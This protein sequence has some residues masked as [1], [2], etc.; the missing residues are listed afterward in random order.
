MAEVGKFKPKEAGEFR[1]EEIV[2]GNHLAYIDNATGNWQVGELVS[3]NTPPKNADG[4]YVAK[5]KGLNVGAPTRDIIISLPPKK[6]ELPNLVAAHEINGKNYLIDLTSIFVNDDG[7]IE[8]VLV[9]SA[10]GAGADRIYDVNSEMLKNLDAVNKLQAESGV[11]INTLKTEVMAKADARG[12]AIFKELVDLQQRLETAGLKLAAL[13]EWQEVGAQ[14]AIAIGKQTKA[15]QEELETGLKDL[16][17]KL[18][19]IKPVVASELTST[20]ANGWKARLVSDKEDK[21]E[22]EKEAKE[23]AKDAATVAHKKWEKDYKN[24]D[25]KVKAYDAWKPK[26]DTWTAKKAV[27]DA[28]SAAEQAD[29]ANKDKNPGAEPLPILTD[30]TALEPAEPAKPEKI[31]D[32][33]KEELDLKVA[34][35]LYR[36]LSGTDYRRLSAKQKILIDKVTAEINKRIADGSF[37]GLTAVGGTPKKSEIKL[38]AGI[39]EKILDAEGGK[40]EAEPYKFDLKEEKTQLK[41]KFKELVERQVAAGFDRVRAE[42]FLAVNIAQIDAIADTD[43]NKETRILN[44]WRVCA[45]TEV[46]VFKEEQKKKGPEK[47]KAETKTE[48]GDIDIPDTLLRDLIAD[49]QPQVQTAMREILNN[50]LKFNDETRVL[51][52][53]S[54]AVK[55]AMIALMQRAPNPAMLSQLRKYGIK[56]WDSFRELWKNGMAMKAA[57]VMHEWGQADLRNEVIKQTG[58]WDQMKALKWQLGARILVN[59]AA[60][61]GGALFLTSP[62]GLAMLAGMGITSAMGA[63]AIGGGLGGG[64]RATLQKFI[65]GG[66]KLE[67]R[68]KNKLAELATN[69]RTEI[70]NNVMARR[71][72][73]NI[74]TST[75]GLQNPGDIEF[76]AILAEAIRSASA[77]AGL[78]KGKQEDFGTT[79]TDALQGDAKRLYINALKNARESGM[80]PDEAQRNKLAIAI[81]SLIANNKSKDALK[82]TDPSVIKI[83]DGVMAGYSGVN[84]SKENYG[85]VGAAGTVALGATVGVA[86]TANSWVARGALGGAGGAVTGYKMGESWRKNREFTQAETAFTPVF[87]E[88][89]QLWDSYF[90]N[91]NS[92]TPAQLTTFGERLQTFNRYLKGNADTVADKKIAEYILSNPQLKQQVEN[93]VYQA[94]RRGVLARLT[95]DRMQMHTD[96]RMKASDIK[97][98]DS[99]KEAWKTTGLRTMYTTAGAVAFAGLAIAGGYVFQEV[100]GHY[101]PAAR[102]HAT[103]FDKTLAEEVYAKEAADVFHPGMATGNHVNN[104]H[105]A[106]VAQLEV[107][108]AGHPEATGAGHPDG[109]AT[110]EV[111]P[112]FEKAPAV[113]TETVAR[114]GSPWRS[115]DHFHSAHKADLFKGMSAAKFNQWRDAELDNMGFKKLPN[116]DFLHPYDVKPGAQFELYKDESGVHMRPAE[117]SMDKFPEFHDKAGNRVYMVEHHGGKKVM[118]EV[119]DSHD[120]KLVSHETQY[121]A[122][123]TVRGESGT[124]YKPVKIHGEEVYRGV[125]GK[126]NAQVYTKDGEY[127]GRYSTVLDSH[128]KPTQ[129]VFTP[130][131]KDYIPDT[132]HRNVGPNEFKRGVLLNE[133]KDA[134]GALVHKTT[135]YR[136]EFAPPRATEYRG[137]GGTSWKEGSVIPATEIEKINTNIHGRLVGGNGGGVK[138][139]LPGNA[140]VAGVEVK[141]ALNTPVTEVKTGAAETIAEMPKNV[142]PVI[143]PLNVGGP[144]P[145]EWQAHGVQYSEIQELKDNLVSVTTLKDLHLNTAMDQKGML[146]N[147]TQRIQNT[148]GRNPK[149]LENSEI[150]R[151]LDDRMVMKPYDRLAMLVDNLDKKGLTVF[152]EDRMLLGPD[153]TNG[154]QFEHSSMTVTAGDGIHNL[155]IITVKGGGLAFKV[156]DSKTGITS[157][158]SPELEPGKL[159]DKDF[160][161][162]FYPP[163]LVS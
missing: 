123:G 137:G 143:R 89:R 12:Q 67:E 88:A 95:L 82:S 20:E 145:A 27:W 97:Q 86:F 39:F 6:V 94:Y 80:T 34:Y 126:H 57:K 117:G 72:P 115:M 96:Q 149:L 163:L 62:A 91:P 154:P 125:D 78:V 75:V 2:A 102:T 76:S 148:L 79:E 74:S 159:V 48:Q 112:H 142:A 100:K 49:R 132:D 111:P 44:F 124:D 19:A 128:G 28:L 63:A 60:V 104:L 151:A 1:P 26:H 51:L 83:L 152:A 144:V 55:E 84:A 37:T 29:K 134:K 42:S 135:D 81:E 50:E 46:A 106:A 155:D 56:D 66:D 139:V 122:K 119:P 98:S 13:D 90:R 47:R 30:P 52:G 18:D 32:V 109:T 33:I 162:D 133:L 53:D 107:P 54:T 150:A 61:G 131:H 113:A 160:V 127:V 68:K 10:P 161:A 43:A 114:G 121:D 101:T 138:E 36:K 129:E 15:L 146:D 24:W 85:V 87:A 16:K 8:F 41:N 130:F 14:E 23:L 65:F 7:S 93:L 141:P 70:I 17:I 11:R 105:H 31:K 5:M 110:H 153:Y 116:G 69:K 103:G 59:V 118:V 58:A 140:K 157:F 147:L 73:S 92:L 21:L 40:T 156:F 22:E 9:N 158:V 45:D 108:G 136:S 77:E 120:H 3:W 71:F 99:D 64:I 35:D 25:D 4:Y 38:V